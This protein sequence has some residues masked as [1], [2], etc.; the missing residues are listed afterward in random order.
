MEVGPGGRAIHFSEISKTSKNA[1]LTFHVPFR[2][3]NLVYSSL[4][5]S[6]HCPHGWEV[7][8]NGFGGYV[9]NQGGVVRGCFVFI[10]GF[11]N[12]HCEL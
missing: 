12:T 10:F 11:W 2:C 3:Q 4:D 1:I 8:K 5:G 9:S 7:F 6:G